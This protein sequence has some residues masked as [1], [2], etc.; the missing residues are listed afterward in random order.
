MPP[1]PGIGGLRYVKAA[2]RGV[3]CFE[4]GLVLLAPLRAVPVRAL[5]DD[6][7]ARPALL[8][9]RL[10]GIG[11]AAEALAVIAVRSA[12]VLSL[13]SIRTRRDRR[14]ERSESNRNL[15]VMKRCVT[16]CSAKRRREKRRR[17]E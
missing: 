2:R 11:A 10:A 7:V 5:R 13:G 14:G 4:L 1:A 17:G 15:H 8:A 6:R 3:N 12:R 9:L 16:G